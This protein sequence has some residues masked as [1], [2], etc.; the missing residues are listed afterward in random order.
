MN[1]FL[2]FSWSKRFFFVGAERDVPH[3]NVSQRSFGELHKQVQE[4]VRRV[5]FFSGPVSSLRHFVA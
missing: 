5:G 1:D 3:P 4:L 2:K